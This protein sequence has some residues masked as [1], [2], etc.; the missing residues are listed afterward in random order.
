[1]SGQPFALMKKPAANATIINSTVYIASPI[2]MHE[3]CKRF[4][5]SYYI[6][7]SSPGLFK[8]DQLQEIKQNERSSSSR[9]AYVGKFL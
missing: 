2:P 1:L 6:P 9:S 4:F 3:V 8:S 7:N 5:R